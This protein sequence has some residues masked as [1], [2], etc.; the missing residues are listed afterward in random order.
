MLWRSFFILF[1]SRLSSI[2]FSKY[3]LY[4]TYKYIIYFECVDNLWKLYFIYPST[5]MKS[6]EK[7]NINGNDIIADIQELSIA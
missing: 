4:L 3:L 6:E 5:N 7:M 1:F 2:L